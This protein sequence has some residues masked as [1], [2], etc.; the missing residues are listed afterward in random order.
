M[1]GSPRNDSAGSGKLQ[2]WGLWS[3]WI[4]LF[5]L[6]SLRVPRERMLEFRRMKSCCLEEGM[7]LLA[8]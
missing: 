2:E 4:K 7:S 3:S 5:L 6:N 1:G 8:L